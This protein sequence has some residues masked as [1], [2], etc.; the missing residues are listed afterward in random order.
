M[1]F[2]NIKNL[3]ELCNK[4]QITVNDYQY[5]SEVILQSLILIKD[6]DKNDKGPIKK[7]L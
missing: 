7:L 6:E 1:R 5:Y 4:L 2:L 3:K